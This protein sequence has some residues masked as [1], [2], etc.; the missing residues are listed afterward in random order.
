MD[1]VANMNLPIVNVRYN[2]QVVANSVECG[3]ILRTFRQICENYP[4]LAIGCEWQKHHI[5]QGS[6]LKHRRKLSLLQLACAHG[7]CVIIRISRLA[8]MPQELMDLL[9][10]DQIVK[11]GIDPEKT[12]AYLMQDYDLQVNGTS[13]LRHLARRYEIQEP[14]GLAEMAKNLLRFTMD[15]GLWIPDRNWEEELM[16]VHQIQYA[17]YNVIVVMELLRYFSKQALQQE[18]APFS[19]LPFQ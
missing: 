15:A 17:A 13:D 3:N 12:G 1:L 6:R 18:M 7:H 9:N 16:L 10:N 19:N 2:V 8:S 5:V 4:F 14:Y 11:I